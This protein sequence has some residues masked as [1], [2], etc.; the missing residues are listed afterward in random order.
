MDLSLRFWPRID[1]KRLRFG[2][3]SLLGWSSH[4]FMVATKEILEVQWSRKKKS[5]KV[6]F[7][8][9]DFAKN[10]HSGFRKQLPNVSLNPLG[11]YSESPP[12]Q[13]PFWFVEK[14]TRTW[15]NFCQFSKLSKMQ[16]KSWLL[17]WHDHSP[18]FPLFSLTEGV[19]G[20]SILTECRTWQPNPIEVPST[21]RSAKTKGENDDLLTFVNWLCYPLWRVERDASQ[22]GGGVTKQFQAFTIF[23][24]HYH[25][26]F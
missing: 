13:N 14:K 4:W 23:H 26:N 17:R 12:P 6:H 24:F 22:E 18:L 3:L 20:A 15:T 7:A 8:R 11:K 5:F 9:L 16:K 21:Q 2:L 1:G 10:F 19:R 25:S